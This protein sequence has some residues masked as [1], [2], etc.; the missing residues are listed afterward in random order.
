MDS[1]QSKS[2]LMMFHFCCPLC[3]ATPEALSL[4]QYLSEWAK[5]PPDRLR[6]LLEIFSASLARISAGNSEWVDPKFKSSCTSIFVSLHIISQYFPLTRVEPIEDIDDESF[7]FLHS[8][9]ACYTPAGRRKKDRYFTI[10]ELACKVQTA[11]LLYETGLIVWGILRTLPEWA[12]GRLL[13]DLNQLR[14]RLL[15]ACE[16]TGLNECPQCGRFTTILYGSG[17]PAPGGFC[18]W[19]LD[20]TD[21]T[22]MRFD[23]DL[24]CDQG[25]SVEMVQPDYRSPALNS[26][27]VLPPD[28]LKPSHNFEGSFQEDKSTVKADDAV[29]S[30]ILADMKSIVPPVLHVGATL[31]DEIS[32]PQWQEKASLSLDLLNEGWQFLVSSAQSV[33][34]RRVLNHS[35]PDLMYPSDPQSLICRI[36]LRPHNEYYTQYN[37]PIPRPENSNGSDAAGIQL[38]ISV[39]R[40]YLA[41]AYLHPIECVLDFAVQGHH[42]RLA[43]QSLHRNHKQLLDAILSKVQ[44]TFETDCVFERLENFRGSSTRKKLDLYF[45][46][47]DDPENSFSI[48]RSLCENFPDREFVKIFLVLLSIYDSCYFYCSRRKQYHRIQWHYK[49]LRESGVL[50]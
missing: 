18:R 25:D 48:S 35:R 14:K 6:Q 27:D 10:W 31:T 38:A 2:E 8:C 50:T 36:R 20:M 1:Q 12:S 41:D 11:N 21:G 17:T 28:F 47:D 33:L 45:Q 5:S 26:R 29:F 46:A 34:S 30:R 32:V 22:V 43:F 15:A 4:R 44:P 9:P 16:A 13:S 49:M 42:E 24:H 39:Y 37:R 3:G 19:C 7:S 40:P 23:F